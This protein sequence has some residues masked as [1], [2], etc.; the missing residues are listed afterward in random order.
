MLW[1]SNSGWW[2]VAGGWC[3]WCGC[4]ARVAGAQAEADIGR[5]RDMLQRDP[6]LPVKETCEYPCGG[7]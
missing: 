5:G 7:W 6:A 3:G 2:L 4:V 1:G